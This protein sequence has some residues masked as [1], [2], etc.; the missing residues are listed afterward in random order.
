[1]TI[2]V[3]LDT[4]IGTDIDDTWALAMLLGCPEL[5]LRLV[6][7]ATGD[8]T[9]RAR[10][11]AGILAAGG[12][13]DVPIGVG[14]PTTLPENVPP[15][16]QGRFADEIALAGHNGGVLEDGVAALVDGVMGSDDPVTIIAIGPLT[17]VAAALEREP[18]I[19]RNARFVGMH[20]SIRGFPLDSMDGPVPEY[21]VLS[22]I[23]ACRAVFAADWE[24]TI[25]PLDTCGSIV[26]HGS[27][28]RAVR[29]T[30][31]SLI[32]ALLRN[33]EEWFETWRRTVGDS[34]EE[35]FDR[36]D[37]LFGDGVPA[38]NGE[39]YFARGST[40]L[41]DTVAVYLAYDDSMLHIE[42]MPIS[43]DDAGVTRI[44]PGAPEL[45]VATTWHDR[46]AFF[47]HL[48][49]RLTSAG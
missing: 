16:P 6:V 44:S 21:N 11:A 2:P 45:Q 24:K 42:R 27:R 47:D 10:L 39:P 30:S 48:V 19:A 33:Y 37:K 43:V 25:A 32:G 5:D 46:D 9:Y 36:Y 15:T 34:W 41:F 35:S 22:D 14:I 18:A 17:N 23:A 49:D 31:S 12:R 13:S 1:V 26:L 7:T 3:I 4:D 20:G 8:T 40:V 38:H 29:D 28:Y